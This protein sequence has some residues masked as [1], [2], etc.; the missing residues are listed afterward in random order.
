MLFFVEKMNNKK[1]K[2]FCSSILW[3]QKMD[4]VDRQFIVYIKKKQQLN[5]CTEIFVFS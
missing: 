2:Y 4:F 5:V 3:G 1:K